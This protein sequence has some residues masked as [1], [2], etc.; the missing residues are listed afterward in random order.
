MPFTNC[1][2][3]LRGRLQLASD[4]YVRWPERLRMPHDSD[5]QA[6]VPDC[7][8]LPEARVKGKRTRSRQ[9]GLAAPS[10]SW[11][12]GSFNGP[13]PTSRDL[14]VPTNGWL[15]ITRE[16]PPGAMSFWQFLRSRE[17]IGRGL[18]GHLRLFT[19]YL[20]DPVARAG[21]PG[22]ASSEPFHCLAVCH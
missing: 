20:F 8:Q 1:G 9:P 4:H 16:K 17:S 5:K 11:L 7:T 18:A 10:V 6:G 3:P 13:W 2:R 15:K 12:I 21:R 19:S 14:S 22:I